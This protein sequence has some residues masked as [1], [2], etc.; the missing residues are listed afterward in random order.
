MRLTALLLHVAPDGPPS[1]WHSDQFPHH[2][3]GQCR[4]VLHVRIPARARRGLARSSALV[5]RALRRRRPALT[6]RRRSDGALGQRGALVRRWVRA[7]RRSLG[8]LGLQVR[9]PGA[10]AGLP[11]PKTRRARGAL[12]R[13]SRRRCDGSLGR[14]W[15][16]AHRLNLVIDLRK[17]T[18]RP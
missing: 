3:T 15:V 14:R 4:V 18:N 11:S 9:I 8:L 2:H 16:R 10:R 13:R 1:R 6:G 17:H 12:R 5:A 7:R